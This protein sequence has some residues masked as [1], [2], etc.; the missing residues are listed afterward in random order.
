M[1]GMDFRGSFQSEQA[2]RST[3]LLM[4]ALR[5]LLLAAF[6][7]LGLLLWQRGYLGWPGL[8]ASSG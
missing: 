3:S 2:C 7:A 6:I 8:C 1:G 4:P 5:P